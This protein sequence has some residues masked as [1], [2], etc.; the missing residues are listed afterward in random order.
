[1]ASCEQLIYIFCTG[2]NEVLRRT[3][4]AGIPIDVQWN[5]IDYMRDRNDFTVDEEHFGDIK[6]FVDQLH[7][8][9]KERKKKEVAFSREKKAKL[10]SSQHP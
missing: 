3:Q 6:Q 1:V 7:Q 9:R 4:R 5:D 10:F 8:V 2:T